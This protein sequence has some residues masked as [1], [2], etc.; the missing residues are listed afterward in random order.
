MSAP[1]PIVHG[2]TVSLVRR[3]ELRQAGGGLV[4]RKPGFVAASVSLRSSSAE[5]VAVVDQSS[6]EVIG[7]VEFGR[8]FMTV[9]PGKGFLGFGGVDQGKFRGAVLPGMRL[10]MVGKM[11]EVRARRCVGATQAFVEGQLV[12]EGLITGMWV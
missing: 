1:A 5:N 10:T 8:A 6:G 9:H 2:A 11:I 12:Y 7:T 3:G 4:P